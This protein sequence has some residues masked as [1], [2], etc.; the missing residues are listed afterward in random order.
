[1]PKLDITVARPKNKATREAIVDIRAKANVLPTSLARALG[2]LILGTQN[3]KIRT[4][5][6]QIIQFAGMSKVFVEIAYRVSCKTVFF[7]VNYATLVLL[8]Q[9]FARKMKL[10]LK[11]PNNS[12][13]DATFTDPSTQETCTITVVASLQKDSMI[14]PILECKPKSA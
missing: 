11:H 2:C 4:V 13:I 1:M 12:S 3:L 6:R 7:L 9:P 14:V 10:S 5:S 8:R